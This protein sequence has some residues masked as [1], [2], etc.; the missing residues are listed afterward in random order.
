[1][2]VD[3]KYPKMVGDMRSTPTIAPAA[4][5]YQAKQDETRKLASITAAAADK[6]KADTQLSDYRTANRGKPVTIT[7]YDEAGLPYDEQVG[8]DDLDDKAVRS[9]MEKDTTWRPT[10]LATAANQQQKATE[11][12]TAESLKRTRVNIAKQQPQYAGMSDDAIAT[13]I[14]RLPDADPSKMDIEQ[15]AQGAVRPD[16]KP[17]LSKAP[18]DLSTGQEIT[19]ALGRGVVGM[20]SPMETASRLT[21]QALAPAGGE[22]EA[23][24]QIAQPMQQAK[25]DIRSSTNLSLA[26]QVMVGA[27]ESVP[28]LASQ[29]AAS[30][31]TGGGATPFIVAAVLPVMSDSYNQTFDS[32]IA[33]GG[34][35]QDA[36]LSAGGKAIA[37]GLVTALTSRAEFGFLMGNPAAQN[38]IRNFVLNRA[39]GAIA[40]GGQ[41]GVEQIGQEV[42]DMVVRAANDMTPVPFEQRLERAAVAGLTGA[43]AGLGL[44]RINRP[45]TMTTQSIAAPEAE[46]EIQQTGPSE[47]A[48]D[49][50]P[51]D[52]Q[53]DAFRETAG[54]GTYPSMSDEEAEAMI[55]ASIA[56]LQDPVPFTGSGAASSPD[57]VLAPPT[58]VESL[59]EAPAVSNPLVGDQSNTPASPLPQGDANQ[60]PVLPSFVSTKDTNITSTIN[61]LGGVVERLA[62]NVPDERSALAAWGRIRRMAGSVGAAEGPSVL[63][64]PDANYN[65][66]DL[67]RDID[68]IREQAIAGFEAGTLAIDVLAAFPKPESPSGIEPERLAGGES[69]AGEVVVGASGL[70]SAGPAVEGDRPSNLPTNAGVHGGGR[71]GNVLDGPVP[72]TSIANPETDRRS[73]QPDRVEAVEGDSG[74]VRLASKDEGTANQIKGIVSKVGDVNRLSGNANV[75]IRQKLMSLALGRDATKVE[76]G[77]SNLTKELYRFAGIKEGSMAGMS[78]DL[79]EWA[80]SAPSF[81]SDPLPSKFGEVYRIPI[82]GKQGYAVRVN[83][84]NPRGGGDTILW[85]MED[86]KAESARLIEQKAASEKSKAESDRLAAEEKAKTDKAAEQEADIDGF[87]SE[88][89]PMSLGKVVKTLNAQIRKDGKVKT[90]KE[91][92]RDMVAAGDVKL[93]TF[94]ESV[95]KPMSRTAFNRAT[96][97][98]QA[99]HEKKM[100]A[101]GTKTV[102]LINDS[103]L[104]KTAYD[105]AKH[106]IE[107]KAKPESPKEVVSP[108]DETTPKSES[109]EPWQM[110]KAE[111][112]KDK[113]T[114]EI[115]N[116]SEGPKPNKYKAGD[117]VIDSYGDNPY[118]YQLQYVDPKGLEFNEEGET[119]ERIVNMPS[120]QKYIEWAKQGIEPNP[121]TIV[122]K[123]KDS[124]RFSTNRRRVVAAQEAGMKLIPAWVEMGRHRDII[125]SAIAAGKP[126]PAE[127]LKDYPDLAAKANP[128]IPPKA[129]SGDGGPTP[130]EKTVS[131]SAPE[132][133]ADPISKATE[134]NEDETFSARQVDTDATRA[135]VGLDEMPSPERKTWADALRKAKRDGLATTA[136]AKAQEIISKPYAM[137]DLETAGM[138]VKGQELKI[139]HKKR[140]KEVD[141]MSDGGKLATVDAEL[142][143]IENELD[144]IT[145]AIRLSG[146]EKGR[147]LAAQKLTI[148]TQFDLASMLNRAKA[149]KGSALTAEER[150][151]ITD[152]QKQNES[153]TKRVESLERGERRSRAENSVQEARTSRRAPKDIQSKVDK[154]KALL[155]AGCIK[156]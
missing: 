64:A 90:I 50:I 23:S 87:G 137:S 141:K 77:I 156:G 26:Q 134:M 79:A 59:S 96:N 57:P 88:L 105:Y 144:I 68:I 74:E 97:Q 126:V 46:A 99:A 11:K 55:D 152:L 18:L 112:I 34:S 76:S 92:V 82:A 83:T 73:D 135:A 32:V 1:M 89:S 71:K 78:R 119:R 140:L 65:R 67:N 15:K 41:E 150:Q 13:A 17:D 149:K 110:T 25:Q 54:T 35:V 114:V 66:E 12:N 142:A 3:P 111:F 100:K 121:I 151:L 146:T 21:A 69:V 27:V 70:P 123:D 109:K 16:L 48:P 22:A 143:A 132:S 103:V 93:S 39:K 120:T 5:D 62:G 91:H 148:N 85:S 147:G 101:G 63:D 75:A 98:E 2:V 86:A 52:R 42:T 84:A 40:E 31:A 36:N 139:A 14:A 37:D 49:N 127:V 43:V 7:R 106:L 116:E 60:G 61:A 107:S 81:V 8:L 6:S 130:K 113:D 51:E 4:L 53:P 38:T 133:E 131:I 94:E 30:I 95:I 115:N 145:T 102:Y 47:P 122:L 33:A 104:G 138:V 10:L 9:R 125:E 129:K 72:P 80:K 45:A 44:P 58:A 128:S 136:T 28:Q 153:L 154:L 24:R 155:N 108:R 124:R 56:K 19:R 117:W 29:V 20:M 118:V